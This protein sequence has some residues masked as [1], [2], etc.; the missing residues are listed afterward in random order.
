[1]M[2]FLLAASIVC[3]SI[4]PSYQITLSS[5]FITGFE[6]GIFLRSNPSMLEDYGCPEPS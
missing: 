3:L 5:D 1:M 2:K 4:V 6:S